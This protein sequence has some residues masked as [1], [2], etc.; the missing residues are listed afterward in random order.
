MAKWAGVLRPANIRFARRMF[1]ISETSYR[2]QPKLSDENELIA[3]W[4]A[5]LTNAQK[6][7]GFGLCFLHLRSVEGFGWN[8]KRVYR[9]YPELELNMQIKSRN[10]LQ[11]DKREP[12]AV[13]EAPNEVWSMDFMVEA[14][15]PAVRLMSSALSHQI[16]QNDT[17]QHCTASIR[18]SPAF[19]SSNDRILATSDNS[20]SLY[21]DL[22]LSN[23]PR[24]RPRLRHTFAVA[25]PA[26][27]SLN[28][29]MICASVKRLVR[30]RLL[31]REVVQTQR[32]KEGS[33]GRRSGNANRFH[34][35]QGQSDSTCWRPSFFNVFMLS[36]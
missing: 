5:A 6:A 28:I 2:Y 18:L 11:R 26:S 32:L 9:N 16:F 3:D 27:C 10:R 17:M 34:T 7:W 20:I 29:P 4:L 25:I 19:S 31:P 21:F 12:L 13:P 33:F 24:L 36:K 35:P 8:H 15:V 30:I 23:V 22:Y 1:S 14:L